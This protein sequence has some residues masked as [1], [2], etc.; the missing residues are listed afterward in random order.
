MG[1]CPFLILGRD[2]AVVSRQERRCVCN[3]RALRTIECLCVRKE[4]FVRMTEA[5]RARGS[6]SRKLVATGFLRCSIATGDSLSQQ[7][8]LLLCRDRDL[9]VTTK[10]GAVRALGCIN[11][12]LML[13][14]GNCVRDRSCVE[15]RFWCCDRVG[16][17][18]GPALGRDNGLLVRTN[19]HDQCS[20]CAT[21]RAAGA[22][23]GFCRDREFSIATDVTMFSIAIDSLRTPIA[24]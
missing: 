18:E 15:T 6:M 4:G 3:R 17:L 14:Y 7:R 2:I 8:R 22:N 24:T 5:S 10:S 16:G 20:A 19:A 11:T 9:S 23:E 1:Y 12:I 13:R 21:E